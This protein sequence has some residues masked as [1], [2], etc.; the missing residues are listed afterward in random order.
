MEPKTLRRI[1]IAVAIFAVTLFEIHNRPGRKTTRVHTLE[2]PLVLSGAKENAPLKLLPAGTTLYL[3]KSYPEGFTRYIIYVN[4]DHSPLAT[5]ELD[6]PTL[7]TPLTA[8]PL[9]KE[10]LR[11]LLM[12]NPIS[13]EELVSILRSGQLSK[14]RNM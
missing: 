7:I 4:V 6:D 12:R 5:H 10:D 2:Y 11:R 8:F 1:G 3:N 13:K 9:D 14:K